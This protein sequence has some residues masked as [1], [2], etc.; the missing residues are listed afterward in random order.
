MPARARVT[1]LEAVT[2]EVRIHRDRI[3]VTGTIETPLG[4]LLKC[5]TVFADRVRLAY[6][7]SAWGERPLATLRTGIVTLLPAGLRGDLFV[8]CANGGAPERFEVSERF[9]AAGGC[10]HG[11]GVSTLV[12]ASAMFGATEGRLVIDDG[13][14]ELELSW[15]AARAAALPL[16]TCRSVGGARFVRVAFSLS[17]IDETHRPGAPLYDFDLTLKGK[18]LAA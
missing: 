1:D 16:F 7:F 3:E 14:T 12:S 13:S 4:S 15:P 18:S 8:T 10:D 9:A 6:G 5:V 11:A 2:P 17:E